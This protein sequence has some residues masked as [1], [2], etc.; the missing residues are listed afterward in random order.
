MQVITDRIAVATHGRN[1]MVDLTGQVEQ[2]LARSGLREGTVTVFV[3]GSTAGVTTIEFEPGLLQDVPE[4]LERVAPM[5]SR[6]HHDAT[7]HDGNGYAHVRAALVG[8][9]LSVPFVDGSLLLGTW[10]QIVLIDFDNRSRQREI[11][12]QLMGK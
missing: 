6:Y 8:A 10:Q 12:V 4:A 2:C 11:V 7:W 1:H 3:P 5:G 9:S